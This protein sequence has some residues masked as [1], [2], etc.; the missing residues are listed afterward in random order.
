MR[1]VRSNCPARWRSTSSI[2]QRARGLS[3]AQ[4]V[5][6]ALLLHIAGGECYE[7]V[8]VLADDRCLERGLRYVPPRPDALRKFLEA[9]H[10]P[11]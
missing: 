9:F 10:D 2:K 7:D 4:Y 11:E 6:S 1:C 5:E 8:A 3:E